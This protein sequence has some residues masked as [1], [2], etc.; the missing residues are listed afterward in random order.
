MKKSFSTLQHDIVRTLRD[1]D[2][3][4]VGTETARNVVN[5]AK[6]L[7][8]HSLDLLKREPWGKKDAGNRMI[9]FSELGTPCTRQLLY[10][11]YHPS[12]GTPPMAEPDDPYLPIKFTYGDYIEELVFFL[13]KEAGHEVSDRQKKVKSMFPSTEW[14]VEGSMDGKIDGVL[15]DVKSAADMSFKKYQRM[16]LDEE[17][18]SFGYRWQLDGYSYADGTTERAFLFTN[19]HD[20]HIHVI[21]RSDTELLPIGGRVSLIG[22]RAEEFLDKGTLPERIPTKKTVN[23][24]ELPM[25]CSYCKFKWACYEGNVTGYISSGRPI[26]FVTKTPKGESFVEGKTKIRTPEAY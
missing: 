16:G 26:Y 13:A 7:S 12:Y 19:K 17:N 22:L 1:H 11:W 8:L 23:G 5:L 21:D 20:G 24:E 2:L 3:E 4:V 10:K 9:R 25:V 15:V 6:S 18:D 14:Y